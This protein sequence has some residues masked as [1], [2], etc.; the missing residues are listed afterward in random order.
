MGIYIVS[1]IVVAV[2]AGLLW[3]RQKLARELA[4]MAGW[5]PAAPP[6]SPA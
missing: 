1:V 2:G 5:R 6:T 3:Y 4:L